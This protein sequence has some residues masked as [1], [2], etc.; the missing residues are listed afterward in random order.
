MASQN[1]KN[2]AKN[3][4]MLKGGKTDVKLKRC[5]F[6]IKKDRVRIKTVEDYG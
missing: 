6:Y 2:K 5:N 1:K 4:Y 3:S